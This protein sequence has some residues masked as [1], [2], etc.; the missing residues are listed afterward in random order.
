M[1]GLSEDVEFAEPVDG[2]VGCEGVEFLAVS[3]D[4]GTATITV[5]RVNGSEGA[6][7]INYATSNGTA[8]AGSD[9]TAASGTLS[10]TATA[11]AGATMSLA[12]VG[13]AGPV[14]VKRSLLNSVPVVSS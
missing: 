4:P 5:N 1:A 11:M 14:W 13:S 9:Y 2:G 10:S 7:A 8:T 3:G 6:V 12:V